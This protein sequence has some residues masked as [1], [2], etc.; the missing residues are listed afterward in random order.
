MDKMRRETYDVKQTQCEPWFLNRHSGSAAPALRA[1]ADTL[2]GTS[3]EIAGLR[4]GYFVLECQ[5][6]AVALARPGPPASARD[7]LSCDAPTLI[8][9]LRSWLP[10]FLCS[11]AIAAFNRPARRLPRRSGQTT[12]DATRDG[13]RLV[14]D[15][16]WW[17]QASPTLAALR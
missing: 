3:K 16:S 12:P 7:R 11:R 2:K 9:A 1:T 15:L 13:Q 17:R 14:H 5:A 8:R 4:S 10:S 6:L